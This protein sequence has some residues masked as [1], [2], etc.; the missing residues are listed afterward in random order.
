MP[1][2]ADILK[3]PNYVNANAQTKQAIFDKYA[4]QDPN[5]TGANDETKQAIRQR[6][7]LTVEAPAA[8]PAAAPPAKPE[9]SFSRAI[10]RIGPDI[11]EY[12]TGV[13]EMV[14]NP[15]QSARAI[16]G[17][18]EPVAMRLTPAG[19][20]SDVARIANTGTPFTPE[21]QAMGRAMAGVASDPLGTM[22]EHPF[23][24]AITV[25]PVAGQA[26]KAANLP[27]VAAG[28]S[29]AGAVI[30]PVQMA[31]KSVLLGGKYVAAPAMDWAGRVY[32]NLKNPARAAGN[33]LLDMFDANPAAGI[34]ALEQ[35]RN[36]LVTPG[37]NP[38]MT[39]R[40][41]AGGVS[42]PTV[43]ATENRLLG[44]NPE[45]TR[46]L[47]VNTQRNIAALQEQLARVN[48]R[49]TQQANALTPAAKADLE[50]LRGSLQS[51]LDAEAATLAQAQQG[52]TNQ[53]S[54]ATPQ[55]TGA[56]LAERG[57]VLQQEVKETVTAPAYKKAF[58]L[59]GDAGSDITPLLTAARAK[60]PVG[61]APNIT[62]ELD[63]IAA[64]TA[65][66]GVPDPVMGTV[67][68]RVPP[69]ATLKEIDNIRKAINDDIAAALAS[70]TPPSAKTLALLNRF[71][72]EIDN[73]VANS[74][75]LSKEAKDAYTNAL[76]TYRTEYAPRFKTGVAADLFRE[77]NK[78][79][80]R[81][82]ADDT[83]TKF[84]TNETSADQFVTTFRGDAAAGNAMRDGVERL[85]REKVTN[86]AQHEKF[87]QDYGDQINKLDRAGLGLR[88]KLDSL[89]KEVANLDAGRKALEA[90]A[91]TFGVENMGQLVDKALK[92]PSTLDEVLTAANGPA[93][94]ALAQE[95]LQR[96]T[97]N[98]D[99]ATQYL[100]VNADA[101]KKALRADNP[102]TA[103]RLYNDAVDTAKWYDEF[104]NIDAPKATD[105]NIKVDAASMGKFTDA[106]LH[107]LTVVAQDI[108]R[109]RE[110]GELAKRGQESITPNARRLGTDAASEAIG[111][112]PMGF[113]DAKIT[114]ARNIFK[115][116]TGGVDKKVAA[117][118]ARVMYDDPD[119][120]IALLRD[121]AK[122][123]GAKSARR[124]VLAAPI[125]TLN[126]LGK[127]SI[128]V[129]ALTSPQEA[130]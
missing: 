79:Q 1:T 45:L 84:L 66:A 44:A 32:N 17:L 33:T 2:L 93:R 125:K 86:P 19:L 98:L 50:A 40:L 74:P 53:L 96:A 23:Q 61:I 10:S 119:A 51:A 37:Y 73:V 49:I 18:V 120:A 57:Q 75:T 81:L 122:R 106:Q 121:A 12:V 24:T 60:F 64:R 114:A 101:I 130:E 67:R 5:Y 11:A 14:T 116:V 47:Y 108:K 117:E 30:D 89:G 69:I 27:R 39:E 100:K 3:D 31:G 92:S 85:Y 46:Q 102:A 29:R 90:R 110:V 43:A 107:D 127:P 83:V 77:T 26:A 71:H 20:V 115:I 21:Q 129:N 128:A 72:N 35:T 113:L 124:A 68:G 76:T 55:T 4:P 80:P 99:G 42:N 16:A 25:L 95:L 105:V 8:A 7:G 9:P 126:K 38:T 59:A 54:N 65:R 97:Q 111:H 62:R 6:F 63:A 123:Q 103:N 15:R 56:T 91:K 87:M 28:L 36:M 82:L 109:A 41:Y 70:T 48:E 94:A 58:A 88:G 118:L 104:K 78:N 13:K 22:T 112:A 52:I 34:N